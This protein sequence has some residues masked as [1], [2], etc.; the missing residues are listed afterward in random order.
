M[1]PRVGAFD[2]RGLPVPSDLQR[3]ELERCFALYGL[4]NDVRTGPSDFGRVLEAACA[5]R[6]V[7]P[8]STTGCGR[9]SVSIERSGS[10]HPRS[11]TPTSERPGS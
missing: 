11:T 7:T 5:E 4:D 6:G 9:V 1:R 2:G 10:V 3:R 8:G